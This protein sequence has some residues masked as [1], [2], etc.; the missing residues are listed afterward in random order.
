MFRELILMMSEFMLSLGP[1]FFP[2][3]FPDRVDESTTPYPRY[4]S[5]E[6]M[7]FSTKVAFFFFP[8]AFLIATPEKEFK[9]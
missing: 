2:D 8:D 1:F 5:I 7:N 3:A 9:K 4:M 6:E